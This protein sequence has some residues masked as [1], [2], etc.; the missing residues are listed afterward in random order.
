MFSQTAVFHK[1]EGLE[2]TNLV[3]ILQGALESAVL[4]LIDYL[5]LHVLLC[6][7]PAFFIAGAMAYFIPKDMIIRYMGK[8][9]DPRIAYPMATAA[10]FLLAVCSC[11]V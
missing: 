4:T 7:I 6:L 9:A 8:D 3:E 11:T 2:M 10:G 5:S 1:N